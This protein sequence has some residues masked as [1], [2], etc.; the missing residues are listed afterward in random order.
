MQ[1]CTNPMHQLA[2]PYK[3]CAV[4]PN[5]CEPSIRY[6][7]QVTRSVPE[8]LRRLLDIGKN[9]CNLLLCII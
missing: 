4:A 5:I 9:L 8:M 6:L 3:F 1:R 2:M 7:L